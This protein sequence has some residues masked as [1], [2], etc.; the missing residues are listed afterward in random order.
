MNVLVVD[1]CAEARAELR[2]LLEGHHHQVREARHGAEALALARQSPPDLLVSDLLMPVMDGFTLLGQIRQDEQLRDI[3][4]VVYSATY[5][6]TKVEKLVLGLGADAFIVKPAEPDAFME[7]LGALLAAPR[8]VLLAPL[9]TEGEERL[10]R[11]NEALVHKLEGTIR[12]ANRMEEMLREELQQRIL[13][14]QRLTASEALLRLVIDTEPECVKLLDSKGCLQ[15]MNAA[16]LAMIEADN[17]DAVRGMPIL[18]VIVPEYHTEFET[19]HRRVMSGGK[20]T[21]VFELLG[22]KGT[23]RWLE[24]TSVP[25]YEGE[26]VVSALAITRDVTKAKRAQED[27]ARSE[28]MFRAISDHSNVAIVLTQGFRILYANQRLA[29]I[30]GYTP[31]ELGDVPELLALV[32]EEDKPVV[33]SAIESV[34]PDM[35]GPFSMVVTGFRKDGERLTLDMAGSAVDFGEGACILWTAVDLSEQRRVEGA[36]RRSESRFAA[37]FEAAPMVMVISTLAEGRYIDVNPSFLRM[38]GYRREEVIGRTAADLGVWAQARDRNDILQA[39][40]TGAEAPEHEC[41]LRTK[42]GELRVG[43]VAVTPIQVDDVPCLLSLARDVTD[44]KNAETS[45][46]KLTAELELRVEDRTK[47]LALANRELAAFSHSVS[48]DLRA[49]LRHI[50]GFLSM[51]V[52]LAQE[53]MPEDVRGYVDQALC[54]AKRMNQL[55]SD[56]LD[57]SRTGRSALSFSDVDLGDVLREVLVEHTDDW[58]GRDIE[59]D[60]GPLPSVRGDRALLVLALSNLIRNAI[61]FTRGREK[62]AI[63]VGSQAGP[64]EWVFFVRDNGAGFDMR[65]SDRLFGVFQRLH[66]QHEFDGTGIGLANVRQIV[67]RHGGRAWAEGEVDVGATFWFSLPRIDEN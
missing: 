7:R 17:L 47:E 18:G 45:L 24:T 19:L 21:L 32:S 15:E 38:F 35:S 23:R 28:G 53:K 29:E 11:Q 50:N 30:S 5:T 39:V 16:G 12:N 31:E 13:V 22:L 33:R 65:Y 43:L 67:E 62:A 36:L 63:K 10:R 46:A 55:I 58:K 8:P 25:L 66:D 60:V 59:W 2:V 37:A 26:H 4:F 42:S 54:A 57:F 41:L 20:G 9:V 61:K 6:D 44:R 52:D 40:A 34:V 64:Q 27:L 56:L 51:A 48:H 1:D 14:E 49:P 3:P